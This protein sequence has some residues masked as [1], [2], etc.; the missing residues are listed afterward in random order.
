MAIAAAA[1]M[2]YV[3]AFCTLVFFTIVILPLNDAPDQRARFLARLLPGACY[4]PICLI[5]L[6]L[7]PKILQSVSW[8]DVCD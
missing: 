8:C 7:M 2:T 3:A 4:E 1:P 5:E 6:G